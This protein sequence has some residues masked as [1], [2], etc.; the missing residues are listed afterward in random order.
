MRAGPLRVVHLDTGRD[1]RGG[2]VEVL[3]L[4]EGLTRRGLCNRLLAPRGPLLERAIAQGLQAAAWTPIGDADLLALARAVLDLRRRRPDVVHCHSARAHAV[5]VPAARLAGV[6]VVVVSRRVA[7]PVSRHPLSA[8]KYRMP[9]DRYLCVSAAVLASMRASG[10]PESRL[11]LVP[12]GVRLAS[13]DAGESGPSLRALAGWPEDAPVVG[14]FAALTAEKR[15]VDLLAAVPGVLARQPRAR[16]AWI[17]EGP[18]R[19]RL[20]RAIRA[21]GL[22]RNVALLGFRSDAR[23]LLRQCTVAA[24][25]SELEGICVALLEAQVEGVPVV[26]TAVGGV[27]EV[28]TDG[29]TG[30]LVPPGN[31]SAMAAALLEALERPDRAKRW[32]EQA[33]LGV[34]QFDVERMIERTLAEYERC[35]ASRRP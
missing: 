24:L 29:V 11:A 22:E 10:V 6:P 4:A 34:M 27:P 30:R 25:A 16:F 15:H 2:Q 3:A 18:L 17:G 20:E 35:L 26:A 28:V 7:V 12:S 5:G 32:A 1:W 14:T 21:A 8:L 9:V 23:S 33:H 19:A 31:P 13:G